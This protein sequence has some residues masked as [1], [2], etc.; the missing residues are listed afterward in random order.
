MARIEILNRQFA[1]GDAGNPV[2]LYAGVN[3][4]PGLINTVANL[5]L[6]PAV[7]E[8]TILWASCQVGTSASKSAGTG[9]VRYRGAAG[10]DFI[11]FS[12]GLDSEG[13]VVLKS[14][15]MAQVRSAHLE[16]P[17]TLKY[18]MGVMCY[19]LTSA[20]TGYTLRLVVC[21]A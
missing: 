10:V 1:A 9:F 13:I 15:M 16:G 6:K 7:D 18:N 3:G 21:Y 19:P 20:M 4:T 17:V 2:C 5:V 14:D 12:E 8:R 11:T